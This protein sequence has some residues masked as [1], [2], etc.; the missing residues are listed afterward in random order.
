[1][2]TETEMQDTID[3]AEIAAILHVSREHVT[4]RITKRTDFPKPKI[5]VSRKLRRWARSEVMDWASK[6]KQP[7]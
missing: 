6:A 5:N 7:A 4:D 3:T 2:L 1:M